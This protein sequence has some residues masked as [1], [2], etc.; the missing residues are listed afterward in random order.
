MKF[1]VIQG[2]QDFHGPVGT[3][4]V[5]SSN[6][7]LVSFKDYTILDKNMGQHSK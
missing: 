3:L 2:F 1:K 4:D 7:F 6:I 5:R